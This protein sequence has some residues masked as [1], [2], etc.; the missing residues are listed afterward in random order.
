MSDPP[1]RIGYDWVSGDVAKQSSKY[2]WHDSLEYFVASVPMVTREA[3]DG[4]VSMEKCSIIDRVCHGR[5]DSG[6]NFFFIYGAFF[7]DTRVRLPFDEFTIGVLHI[8][9]V[10]PTQLHPNSWGFLQCFRLLSSYKGDFM[11]DLLE[12]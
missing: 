1:L 5:E 8:L 3:E 12:L 7:I 2:R 6:S 11:T 4:I 10:A 9:N